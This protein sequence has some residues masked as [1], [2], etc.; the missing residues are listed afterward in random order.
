MNKNIFSVRHLVGLRSF[1][2]TPFPNLSEFTKS[3]DSYEKLNQFSIVEAFWRTV[4]RKRVDFDKES[5]CE[6]FLK[7][8]RNKYIQLLNT[9]YSQN[10]S[11]S[12]IC[13]IILNVLEYLDDKSLRKMVNN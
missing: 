5:T 7:I 3:I 12:E 6:K 4:A 2:S 13:N 11:F 1:K 8:L 9:D 10:D